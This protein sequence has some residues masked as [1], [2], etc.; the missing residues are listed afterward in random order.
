MKAAWLAA[1]VAA[2]CAARRAPPEAEVVASVRFDGNGG[3]LRG[4]ADERLRSAMVQEQ[5]PPWAWVAPRRLWVPLDERELRLDA[6]RVENWYAHHGYLDARLLGWDLRR[7]GGGRRARLVV[8]GLVEEGPPSVVRRLDWQGFDALGRPALAWLERHAE[9]AVG[10][11]FDLEALDETVEAAREFLG[12]HGYARARVEAAVDAWPEE[13]AVDVVVRAETGPACRVG[14]VRV[15]GDTDVVPAVFLDDRITLRAGEPWRSS[16]LE[17]TRR[18]LFALGVFSVVS[19]TPDLDADTGDA[20]PVRIELVGSRPREVRLGG[21]LSTEGTRLDA[22]ATGSF[23]HRNLFGRLLRLRL[24]AEGGYT[25]TVEALGSGTGTRGPVAGLDASLLIPRFPGRGWSL[26]NRAS[27]ALDVQE[28]Y[29]DAVLALSPALA[30]RPGPRWTAQLSY[31]LKYVD[32][33]ELSVAPSDALDALAA[34]DFRDPY[35]L[36]Y[37]GQ[38]LTWDGRDDAMAPRSGR[39]LSVGLDEAGGPFGGQASF[40]RA[41]LDLRGYAPVRRLAGRR[42]RGVSLAARAG[43]GWIAPYGPDEV[44]QVP[45]AERLRLG[46]ATSVR[47]WTADHLGP[48]VCAAA[49]G[50]DCLSEPGVL[51]PTRDIVPIGGLVSLFGGA[52]LRGYL[53]NGFGAAAFLDAGMVWDELAH[54]GDPGLQPA[55]GLGLRYRSPVGPVRVDVARRLVDEPMFAREPRWALHLALGEA[56]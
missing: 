20:V 56:W 30:W 51:Q 21:R 29:R 27:G 5:S 33:L 24:E 54:V 7:R 40:L 10:Q 47:G 32:Y 41:R 44:R 14:E 19:V 34:L 18:R 37:L 42:L 16:E 6:W 2:G 22:R 49:S 17:R 45:Y 1:L 55:A 9:L 39:Y 13:R 15:V 25:R 48:Y 53:A 31:H 11:R 23:E 38:Q 43:G 36:S 4:T 12:E 46:G 35:L 50:L 3:P 8:T 28:G 26:D 52:E